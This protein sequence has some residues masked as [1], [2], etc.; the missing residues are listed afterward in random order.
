MAN[1]LKN[2]NNLLILMS[3]EEWESCMENEEVN[4]KLNLSHIIG[5]KE[6]GYNHAMIAI[7]FKEKCEVKLSHESNFYGQFLYKINLDDLIKETNNNLFE[8]SPRFLND[9]NS[10][11]SNF[12]PNG[13]YNLKMNNSLLIPSNLE[14]GRKGNDLNHSNQIYSEKQ[15]NIL[16]NSNIKEMQTDEKLKEKKFEMKNSSEYDPKNKTNKTN[17]SEIH[18]KNNTNNISSENYSQD[19]QNSHLKPIIKVRK[20][21]AIKITQNS[22]NEK[23]NKTIQNLVINETIKIQLISFAE[24]IN[25]NEFSSIR[26]NSQ[27]IHASR[28]CGLHLAII[29][30]CKGNNQNKYLN[31]DKKNSLEELNKMYTSVIESFKQ[32]FLNIEVSCL[33]TFESVNII[34]K[35]LD[36]SKNNDFNLYDEGAKI[37]ITCP[38]TCLYENQFIK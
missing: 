35:A 14:E 1:F 11:G 33:D 9:I 26:I 4:N 24:N 38:S 13:T 6:F 20:Q 17:S 8:D 5:R 34:S 21:E 37:L 16:T 3:S 22:N 36:Y 29:D 10:N 7:C 2:K 31:E 32:I 19:K 15:Q 12:N 27:L 18:S 23:L 30:P 25:E 28:S